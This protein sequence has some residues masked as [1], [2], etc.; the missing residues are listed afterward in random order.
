MSTEKK[1]DLI[2]IKLAAIMS[3]IEVV[4]KTPNDR[5]KTMRVWD[6]INMIHPL[7]KKHDII[8]SKRIISYK[9]EIINDKI[10]AQ[11]SIKF[12]LTAIDNSS[13]A[14]EA[15]GMGYN[16]AGKEMNQAQQYALKYALMHL[17]LIP[18]SI[19]GT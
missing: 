8:I 4:K 9:I 18:D 1:P 16:A 11:C 10:L 13:I 2:S 7:L 14:T 19:E 15:I 17:F 6:I 5:Y 3:E 12:I